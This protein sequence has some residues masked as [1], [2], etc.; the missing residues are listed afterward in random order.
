MMPAGAMQPSEE[1]LQEFERQVAGMREQA[2]LMTQQRTA[3]QTRMQ[4]QRLE[5]ESEIAILD[6]EIAK[7]EA[8]VAN[9]ER[10]LEHVKGQGERRIL[11]V[12]LQPR[13][14]VL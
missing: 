9:S 11:E 4:G 2:R 6:I 5:G 1:Q 3:I 14:R 13:R 7:L 12:G 10:I 8:Q